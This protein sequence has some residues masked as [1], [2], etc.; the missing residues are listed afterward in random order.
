MHHFEATL[1]LPISLEEA[2]DFF[3]SPKNLKVITPEELNLVPITPL[4][5]RMYPGQ[6]IQYK[7]KPLFG[8]PMTWVTEI[9]HVKE[10]EYFIDEQRVGPYKIWHHQQHFKAIEG[11]VE[12][13]DIL[14]YLLPLGP[15]G[16]LTEAI[17]VGG[18]VKKIFE[19]RTKRLHEL[20]GKFTEAQPQHY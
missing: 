16:V 10:M 17:L 15:I 11:G 18:E 1:K 6:F 5:E 7:V 4:A 9:T 19:F 12:M 14:D 13:T 2:W 3:S 20:F 8:I